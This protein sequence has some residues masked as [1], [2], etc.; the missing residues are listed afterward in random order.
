MAT[1][2]IVLGN[3]PSLKEIDLGSV[4]NYLSMGMNAAYRYWERI[5][6]YPDYYICC[7]LALYETHWK[8]INEFIESRRFKK[9]ILLPEFIKYN[10][11]ITREP[12]V[13]LLN[14]QNIQGKYGSITTGSMSVYFF[15]EILKIR[16]I[17]IA[18]IDCSYVDL[19]KEA[20]LKC[21][22]KGDITRKLVVRD[23]VERNP[24]YFFD[25][26]QQPDDLYHIP[27]KEMHIRSWEI[28]AR[29]NIDIKNVCMSS[30]LNVFEKQKQEDIIY[31]ELDDEEAYYESKK[32]FSLLVT[33][34][35]GSFDA[36]LSGIFDKLNAEQNIPV[37]FRIYLLANTNA[38]A[39][40]QQ[41]N[42]I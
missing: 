21:R 36:H 23:K 14:V 22:E 31:R 26:Y 34:T 33:I 32:V 12:N 4:S 3:G 13:L 40:M 16:K 7:D 18:G 2:C 11:N 19:I 35:D 6:W 27:N 41:V 9:V 5:G 37:D 15:Y 24:N 17:Y 42:D 28:L 20:E 29:M 10:E 1:K 30:K 25:D 38:N 39:V 8:K